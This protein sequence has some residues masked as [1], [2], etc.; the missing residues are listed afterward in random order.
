MATLEMFG[1][2]GNYPCFPRPL[3][4]R[5]LRHT[6]YLYLGSRIFAREI[7]EHAPTAGRP[8]IARDF[9]VSILRSFVVLEPIRWLA[10]ASRWIEDRVRLYEILIRPFKDFA[11]H[12]GWGGSWIY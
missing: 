2:L 3:T 1:A 4:R 8:D 7:I 5:A 6:P 9:R 10:R 11:K 12:R